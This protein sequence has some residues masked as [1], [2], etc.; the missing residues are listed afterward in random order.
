MV[1]SLYRSSRSTFAT[2]TVGSAEVAESLSA[3]ARAR[4]PDHINPTVTRRIPTTTTSETLRRL[5]LCR[6]KLV[7][8]DFITFSWGFMGVG[9]GKLYAKPASNT[10]AFRFHYGSVRRANRFDNGESQAG[11][12]GITRAGF[13]H[14]E[15]S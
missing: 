13:I 8:S 11:A 5:N 3:S 4:C 15:K 1:T 2:A 14:A 12:F 7:E 6:E 10:V 9:T